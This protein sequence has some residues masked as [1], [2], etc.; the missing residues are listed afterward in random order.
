[1]KPELTVWRIEDER[2]KG[3]FQSN[4]K[5][6]TFELLRRK[7]WLMPIPENDYEIL[8]KDYD[9]LYAYMNKFEKV[10][11]DFLKHNP[12]KCCFGFPSYEVFK[13]WVGNYEDQIAE[14]VTTYRTRHYIISDSGQ[15]VLFVKEG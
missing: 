10:C 3:I 9:N 14:Y 2:G 13:K 11:Q 12:E 6:F 7:L 5:N 4:P 15:Q 1:M 8:R